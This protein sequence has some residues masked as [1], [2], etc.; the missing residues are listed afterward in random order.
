MTKDPSNL[1]SEIW[2]VKFLKRKI[3]DE[4]RTFAYFTRYADPSLVLFHDLLND[5]QTKA[6][7]SLLSRKERLKDSISCRLIH[8]LT[9]VRD[10]DAR[11]AFRRVTFMPVKT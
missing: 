6:S 3:D 7:S 5:S 2:K 8:T 11:I 9:T 10:G 1:K 4:L